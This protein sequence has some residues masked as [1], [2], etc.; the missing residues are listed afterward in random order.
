MFR[1]LLV[2]LDGS[3]NAEQALPHAAWL[4]SKFRARLRLVHVRPEHR[5][6]DRSEALNEDIEGECAVR[7]HFGEYLGTHA[8]RLA[9]AAGVSVSYDVPEGSVERTV[10]E[11]VDQA[12]AD[13][14]VMSTRGRGL[15]LERAI[16][17]VAERILRMSR[18]P[19]YLARPVP[20]APRRPGLP[21]GRIVV[22]LDGSR[23]SEASLDSAAAMASTLGMGIVLLTVVR[24]G[25]APA[26]GGPM[27]A[28][29]KG[30]QL[31][32]DAQAYLE[33]IAG[34]LRERDIDVEI[35]VRDDQDPAGAILD[36][37]A[38]PGRDMIVMAAQNRS[39][40]YRRTIGSVTQ[41]VLKGSLLPLLIVPQMEV[42]VAV[43]QVPELASTAPSSS[44]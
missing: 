33:Q 20:G 9:R 16:G 15:G 4:A 13:L 1:S 22:P 21:L 8:R 29:V 27:L 7:A 2:P 40:L 38:Q 41:N 23:G 18:V 24:T 44:P 31:R 35:V 19:V 37:A 6:K 10:L 43:E 11:E 17:S 30:L 5:R 25:T 34:T 28:G 39:R 36:E 42:A 3:A 12:E 14:I 26:S 32:A